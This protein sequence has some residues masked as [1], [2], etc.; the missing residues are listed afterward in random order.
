MPFPPVTHPGDHH[1]SMI[2]PPSSYQLT[3]VSSGPTMS[4]HSHSPP[5]SYS[6]SAH[7][8]SPR[9][10]PGSPP[11]PYTQSSH[12][13]AQHM[14]MDELVGSS[15]PLRKSPEAHY[16]PPHHHFDRSPTH[17]PMTTVHFPMRT[18]SPSHQIYA[19]SSGG[20]PSQLANHSPIAH[21]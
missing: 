20:S 5:P 7:T 6:P 10:Y 12:I 16:L 4:P 1:Q 18:H 13:P 19:H 21:M 15:S 9:G 11:I 3:A 8:T 14:M 2:I 17:S